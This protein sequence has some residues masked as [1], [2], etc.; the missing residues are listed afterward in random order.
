MRAKMKK[1]YGDSDYADDAFLDE[2]ALVSESSLSRM[3][4]IQ[5]RF[6]IHMWSYGYKDN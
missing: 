2:K 6:C 1:C 4:H 3:K 5:I